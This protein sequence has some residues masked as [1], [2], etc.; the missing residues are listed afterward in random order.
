[1]TNSNNSRITKQQAV[2][3]L[4]ELKPVFATFRDGLADQVATIV[5]KEVFCLNSVRDLIDVDFFSSIDTA[6]I[7]EEAMDFDPEA[8]QT[9]TP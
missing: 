8:L 4:N 1:M 7:T 3:R 6:T 9:T 5:G 2:D